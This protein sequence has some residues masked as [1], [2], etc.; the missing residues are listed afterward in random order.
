MLRPQAAL[1]LRLPRGLDHPVRVITSSFLGVILLGT[2]VLTLPLASEDATAS[3]WV[4]ALFT[5]TSAVSVTGLAVVDTGSH[6]SGFGEGVIL[7]L[8]QLGGLGIT[9][10]ATLLAVLL[11]RRL[12]LRTRLLVQTETQSLTPA[13]LRRVVV[14]VV[15]FSLV[16]ELLAAVVLAVRFI[17]SYGMSLGEGVYHAV[18]LAVSSF[19]N[20]GF[21]LHPD[22]LMRYVEDPWIS[23]TVALAVFVGAL[24]FPVAFELLREWR[25]PSTWSVLTRVTVP[26]T[27]ALLVLGTLALLALEWRNPQTFGPLGAG[28]KLVAALFASAQTRSGGL[29]TVD[30]GAM[31]P[32][33]LFLQDVLMF[34]GGGSA[35]VAGGIRVT[36]FAILGYV[37]WA[38]IRGERDVNVG[39]RRI[40]ASTQRQAVG[41]VLLVAGLVASATFTLLALTRF[42][43]EEVLFEVT[44]AATTTGLSTGITSQL[45]D[46]GQLVLVTLMF[47]G[48]VG[49][50]TLASALA[51]RD[52]GSRTRLPEERTI[53]G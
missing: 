47:I 17:A 50:L 39:R 10:F 43:L 44:S 45:P 14:R 6:W 49:P 12:G 15:V 29:N 42:S 23:L 51:L 11:S 25:T 33:S 1:R 7:F 26:T 53:V 38:E 34:I 35:S 40:P 46:A 13:D 18:F 36:T 8:V 28:E 52:R 2:L 41:V 37:L 3:S 16:C 48:R 21:A 27:L 32:A 20:A 30:V 5:A 22:G 19:N 24:G 31:E 9:T 4:T